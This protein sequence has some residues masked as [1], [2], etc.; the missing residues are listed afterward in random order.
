M[1]DPLIVGQEHYAVARQV[2]KVLQQYKSLQD[3]I[4]ILGMD[5]LSE[6]DKLTV[7]RARKIQR[8]LSQP[9][10]VAEVFTSF[11]GKFVELKETISGFKAILDG[12]YDDT[13]ES[14]FY[15]VGP[16]AE[17][18]EKARQMAS[19]V[20]KKEDKK[21]DKKEAA[22]TKQEVDTTETQA[23]SYYT[24]DLPA[25]QAYKYDS[26]FFNK[27]ATPDFFAA[28]PSPARLVLTVL[29]QFYATRNAIT[30]EI[31]ANPDKAKEYNERL[32]DIAKSLIHIF[33]LRALGGPGLEPGLNLDPERKA[34]L[35]E[36]KFLSPMELGE[37]SD[38]NINEWEILGVTQDAYNQFKED[39]ID[40]VVNGN[41]AA[42]KPT[43]SE[44]DGS[45][46]DTMLQ[47]AEKQG[48]FSNES[49]P[50]TMQKLREHL[51]LICA[52]NE[53]SEKELEEYRQTQASS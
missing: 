52:V 13:P 27:I 11:P 15:M 4:A 25:D 36:F 10:A 22:S 26:E 1:L 32:E 18:E 9:F 47:S 23:I 6:E 49:T 17:V 43:E 37:G 48:L 31:K 44:H 53:A 50:E 34:D 30:E 8:F 51:A 12:K 28:L 14:A 45:V 46:F 41:V 35:V 7:Y 42:I 38:Q 3:I 5:E 33:D 39:M 19:S 29:L 16:I 24:P 2:Q 40:F 21:E 20:G